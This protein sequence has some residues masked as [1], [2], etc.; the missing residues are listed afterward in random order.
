MIRFHVYVHSMH[1]YEVVYLYTFHV[2][3]ILFHICVHFM[4]VYAVVCLLTCSR[5][6][7]SRFLNDKGREVNLIQEFAVYFWLR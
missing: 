3:M 5:H 1:V 7:H 2:N 6:S 4:H